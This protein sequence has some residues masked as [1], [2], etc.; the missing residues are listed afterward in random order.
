MELRSHRWPFLKHQRSRFLSLWRRRLASVSRRESI[1]ALRLH[2]AGR[3]QGTSLGGTDGG[4]GRP[5]AAELR[6]FSRS[7][8]YDLCVLRLLLPA[9]CTS[10]SPLPINPRIIGGS[11]SPR[12]VS[13]PSPNHRGM[14]KGQHT[15][16]LLP[17]EPSPNCAR[18]TPNG[19]PGR[20]SGI[21]AGGSV[22]ITP[23]WIVTKPTAE[24]V[25]RERTNDGV[26]RPRTGA[27]AA[28]ALPPRVRGSERMEKRLRTRPGTIVWDA[29]AVVSP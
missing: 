13:E 18:T 6:H 2:G 12:T 4:G 9:P 14:G 25:R 24:M 28:G 11:P 10:D 7:R 5:H 21:A 29:P 19:T 1:V 22:G 16:S 27:A 8:S 23:A 15:V 26:P 20:D 3:T 17:P